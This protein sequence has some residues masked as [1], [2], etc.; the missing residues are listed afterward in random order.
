[1]DTKLHLPH[2]VSSKIDDPAGFC[3][4]EGEG[5]PASSLSLLSA[6]ARLA[7]MEVARHRDT[8]HITAMVPLILAGTGVAEADKLVLA[9]AKPIGGAGVPPAGG[10]PTT[11]TEAR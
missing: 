9:A 2:G 3:A 6:D 1:M 5:G 10:A 8:A 11:T 4:K 7:L